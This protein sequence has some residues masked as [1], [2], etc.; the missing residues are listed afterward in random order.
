[1]DLGKR[2]D[3]IKL[4]DGEA[5]RL[6]SWLRT[7]EAK[8]DTP[9]SADA[10]AEACAPIAEATNTS[11]ICVTVA[12]EGAALSDDG[13]LV[14]AAAPHVIVKDTVGAGD[15]FMAGLM[16]GLTRGTNPQKVLENDCRLAPSSLH[17][18]EQ[19]RCFPRKS[20]GFSKTYSLP[21]GGCD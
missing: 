9:R 13:N 18:T 21:R 11:R 14:T 20:S 5:G 19:P 17:I 6:A 10:V 16:I 12:E 2:A 1:M 15:A 8:H 7:G 3:V 4:N